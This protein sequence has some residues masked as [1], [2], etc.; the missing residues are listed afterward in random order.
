M[1]VEQLAPR[2]EWVELEC[3]LERLQDPELRLSPFDDNAIEFCAALS[4]SLFRDGE[5]RQHP[6]LQALAFWMRKAELQ[7]AKAEFRAL[8]T[9]QLLLA[10]R[11]LVFH[12]PPSNVDTIFLYSWALSMLTGNAN[13]IRLSERAGTRSAIIC[14]LL[15]SV[16]THYGEKLS[17]NTVVLRYGHESSIN[18]AISA[19]ADVRVIWGGDTTVNLLRSVPFPPHTEELT[20]PDRYSLAI[21][22][23]ARWL[24]H[25]NDKQREIAGRFFNDTYWFDQMACSS[26]RTL[27]WCGSK[28]NCDQAGEQFY[29]YLQFEIE[30]KRYSLATGPRLNRLTFTY[31]AVLDLPVASVR[32]AGPEC[33]IVDLSDGT[34]IHR[35]HSGGGFLFQLRV[36]QLSDLVPLIK[37]KDQTLSQFGFEH[38]ELRAFARALNG[39]GIDRIVPIGA[40]L[41]FH[42]YWDGYDLLRSFTR[43]VYVES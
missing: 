4:T 31:R 41:Q 28:E 20:F 13:V 32:H 22:N 21:L 37:R 7:R 5:A 27:V 40:A 36:D 3:V 10:P 9:E 23:A 43:T 29:R 14:R 1:R 26:P 34:P 2:S 12:V 17:C 18:E 25:S 33:S 8:E 42:R 30:R 19:A 11:G 39:R 24:E 16:M 38:D 15:N 35:E 6:E